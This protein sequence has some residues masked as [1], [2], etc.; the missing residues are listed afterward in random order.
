MQDKLLEVEAKLKELGA[1]EMDAN[2][3]L[4]DL[5]R[6]RDTLRAELAFMDAGR[7][8]VSDHAV[9]RFLERRLGIDIEGIRNELRMMA[10]EAAP[11]KKN[12]EHHWHHSG[13]VIVIGEC[14]QIIT[15]LSEEQSE[16]HCG[17]RLANGEK[18]QDRDAVSAGA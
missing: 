15:V 12:G 2:N 8:R 5:R 18:A 11:F 17:R 13:V 3:R 14:G 16:K 9:L 4:A 7:R 6:K 1:L 10:D